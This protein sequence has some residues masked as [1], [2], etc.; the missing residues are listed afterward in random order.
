MRFETRNVVAGPASPAPLS[1]V[2]PWSQTNLMRDAHGRM[3]VA[4]DGWLMSI[5]V[6]MTPTMTP[7]PLAP[8]PPTVSV[9]AGLSTCHR[10]LVPMFATVSARARSSVAAVSRSGV[11]G[12]PATIRV[13]LGTAATCSRSVNRTVPTASSRPRQSTRNPASSTG[14]KSPSW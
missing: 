12:M 1:G 10:P 6:S 4:N 9:P 5:P 11:A 8:L 13:T 7:A 14:A 3:L 2:R